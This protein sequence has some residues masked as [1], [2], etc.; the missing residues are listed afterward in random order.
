MASRTLT[1]QK[2]DFCQGARRL[3]IKD[4]SSQKIPGLELPK[5]DL[6]VS[7]FLISRAGHADSKAPVEILQNKMVK[8][9]LIDADK[10]PAQ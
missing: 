9:M 4:E 7:L 10:S 8:L 6:C 2:K 5:E 1:L 3:A